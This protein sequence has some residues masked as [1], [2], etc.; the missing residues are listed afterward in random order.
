MDGSG[1]A[2][3]FGV[4]DAVPW[5]VRGIANHDATE[6]FFAE[7][8]TQLDRHLGE[9]G[10]P[11]DAELG[12]VWHRRRKESERN[13]TGEADR[14]VASA[15][16][17]VHNSADIARPHGIGDGHVVEHRRCI[18]PDSAPWAFGFAEHVMGIWVE[19]YT[20]K[21]RRAHIWRVT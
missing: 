15:V 4:V 13:A 3:S 7:F 17:E 10:A 19:N 2:A 14:A 5:G 11:E 16:A 8:P 1:D 9:G 18:V 21:P 6:R 12:C 20:P